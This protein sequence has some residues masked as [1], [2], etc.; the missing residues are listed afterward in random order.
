MDTPVSPPVTIDTL[1]S[2]W[3]SHDPARLAA[4]YTQDAVFE[5]VPL[6]HPVRGQAA[7]L[8]MF[9]ALFNAFPDLVMTAGNR[10]QQADCLAWEWI[11][12]ATH[13]GEFN[14]IPATGN[15]VQLRGASFCSLRGGKI[16]E[17]RE[18]WD[19]NTVLRQIGVSS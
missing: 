1:V 14:G 12:T 4:C 16:A 9:T 19:L 11:I 8:A 13:R 2:A 18:Y 7:L 15:A 3:N 10:A 5:E 17:N 6:G